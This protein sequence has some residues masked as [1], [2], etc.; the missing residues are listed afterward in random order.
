MRKFIPIF[1]VLFIPVANAATDTCSQHNTQQKCQNNSPECQWTGSICRQQCYT[2]TEESECPSAYCEWTGESCTSITCATRNPSK[3]IIETN[4]C[5]L[6]GSE[7]KKADPNNCNNAD[8]TQCKSNPYCYWM[9]NMPNGNQ[10]LSCIKGQ[11]RPWLGYP[12]QLC[13]TEKSPTNWNSGCDVNPP[14]YANSVT[15]SDSN[16]ACSWIATC[17][18]GTHYVADD[19]TSPKCVVCT[20]T[21]TYNDG[22]D[23]AGKILLYDKNSKTQQCKMCSGNPSADRTDCEDEAENPTECP[24]GQYVNGNECTQCEEDTFIPLPNKEDIESYRHYETQCFDCPQNSH[25]RQEEEEPKR[26]TYCECNTGYINYALP[27]RNDPKYIN[28]ATSHNCTKLTYIPSSIVED[29]DELVYLFDGGYYWDG[30]DI[31]VDGQDGIKLCEPGYYCEPIPEGTNPIKPKQN[32]HSCPQYNTSNPGA[33]TLQD[34]YATCEKGMF[35][36][37]EYSD[38]YSDD[39]QT[40]EACPEGYTSN[41]GA[42]KLTDCYKICTP[43]QYATTEQ[44]GGDV[45]RSCEN[46]PNGYTSNE[47]AKGK[48]DC[49]Q[50]CEAGQY[51]TPKQI[52]GDVLRSCENCPKHFTSDEGGAASITKCYMKT[53]TQFCD[54]GNKC[55]TLADI[56]GN[57]VRIYYKEQ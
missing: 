5:Y 52:G 25:T 27:K 8:E 31:F 38:E 41:E 22:K 33:K 53:D 34:C 4:Y 37:T 28:D 24:A 10:C 43:G 42:A 55:T 35:K 14:L 49:Y 57:D 26:H 20:E 30:S 48:S 12:Y 21:G 3:C 44:I 23:S 11:R 1:I 54:K 15:W 17:P 36:T 29:F 19:N 7:C 2:F 32:I 18:P 6:N 50:I 40:C 39:I 45:L 16:D 9:A 56:F 51:A 13:I 46:C 47:G